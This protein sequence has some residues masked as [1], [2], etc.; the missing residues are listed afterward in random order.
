MQLTGYILEDMGNRSE[1]KSYW[2]DDLVIHVSNAARP[3]MVSE[4]E[5]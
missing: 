3:K 2:K 4:I 5:V 1:I